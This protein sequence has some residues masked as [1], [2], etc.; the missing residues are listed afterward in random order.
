MAIRPD[1]PRDKKP[2]IRHSEIQLTALNNLY[3]ENEHP[4]LEE[5]AAL[6]ENLGMD[7][8]AVNAWFA[9]KRSATKKKTRGVNHPYN[10][11]P[12]HLRLDDE[13]DGMS[14]RPYSRLSTPL[15]MADFP[16]IPTSD[17]DAHHVDSRH[18]FDSEI[19][20]A[21][22]RMRI[23]PTP[24]QREELEKLFKL[25]THPSREEREALGNR[26]GMRYQSVTNWF[27]NMRSV[28][29]K[30]LEDQE[31]DSHSVQSAATHN[32][33]GANEFGGFSRHAEPRGY[34]TLP[35]AA[36]HPSL[37]APMPSHAPAARAAPL[38]Q[39]QAHDSY[40]PF[41]T[42]P[43]RRQGNPG[44]LTR[45]RRTRPEPHQL[46]ALKKLFARTANPS[47]EERGALALEIGMD[48]GKVTNWFR[49]LRQTARK[50]AQKANT[51]DG[52]ESMDYDDS[53]PVSRAST[54]LFPSAYSSSSVSVDG[55]VEHMEL[56]GGRYYG[57]QHHQP[58]SDG[59]SEEDY[60]EAV[61]PPPAPRTTGRRRMDVGF[62]TGS[63]D[64]L[65]IPPHSSKSTSSTSST[66]APRVEDAMLLLS[67]SQ[68]IVH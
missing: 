66:D 61:T 10:T 59:G 48:V 28:M 4:S 37:S 39:M 58:H 62:L 63:N 22:R 14:S 7:P 19:A 67:F 16:S 12:P 47:I 57:R 56:D 50:R 24:K 30:R 31:T 68:R 3:E 54:P 46:E 29:K 41:L 13:Y 55:D 44:P 51:E 36:S 65:P 2:R 26:I 25:N 27:Q 38:V 9:N 42:A 5:R 18:V 33:F 20:G 23:R 40:R 60:E 8:K 35:P 6:A 53:A 15:S 34:P 21:P 17:N 1:E 64:D 43:Q 11:P 45:P 52:D 32:D 49:N